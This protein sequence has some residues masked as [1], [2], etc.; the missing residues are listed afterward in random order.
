MMLKKINGV[1]HES[2]KSIQPNSGIIFSFIFL[3]FK[4]I[5]SFKILSSLLYLLT[6]EQ[7]LKEIKKHEKPVA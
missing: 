4:I 1:S 5:P 2:A 6:G 7:L 3:F